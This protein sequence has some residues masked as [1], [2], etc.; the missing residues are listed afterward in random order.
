MASLLTVIAAGLAAC[1][2]HPSASA[3]GP[4]LSGG[5]ATFAL[6]PSTNPTYIFPMDD[7]SNFN[8][9][10]IDRLQYLLY[11]PLYWFGV[12][13]QPVFNASLSLAPA[14]TWSAD[15]LTATIHLKNYRWS[16]GQP[17][18]ASDVQLWQDIVDANAAEWG[19]TVPGQYPGN[20]V[21][22]SVINSTTISFTFNKKYN[23][24]WA[25]D[26]EL[27]Q[28]TP[29][30]AA[31]NVTSLGAP[32]NS[33]GC[34]P[35][36]LSKC[37]AVYKFLNA[38]AE[39]T[40]TYASSPLWSIVDGPW[41]LKSYNTT[42]QVAFVPNKAYSGPVKPSLSEFIEEPFTSD[43][44]EF[45]SVLS[46]QG[47]VDVGYLPPTDAQDAAHV[48]ADG[49][50]IS[51]WTAWAARFFDMNYNNPTAGPIFKQLYIRQAFEHLMDEK[52]II[53]SI[54]DGY[55]SPEYGPIPSNIPNPWV[56]SY[57]ESD[58]YPFSIPAAKSLITSHGWT[59]ENGTAVCTKPGTGPSDCGAGVQAGQ[60]LEFNLVYASGDSA[61][62]SIM[63]VYKSD[64]SEAGI[65][66]NLQDA[67]FSTV[68]SNRICQPG[69]ACMWDMI[70]WGGWTYS[71]D[72]YPEGS[73][74]FGT[75]AGANRGNYSNPQNDAN[76]AAVLTA[77][78]SQANAAMVTYENYL[79]Q[80]AAQI[81]MPE[82]PSQITVV[83]DTL[84]GVLPQNSLLAMTPE[85][86]Y[87]TK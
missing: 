40:S 10:N 17:V 2:S 70:A 47:G 24:Q 55:G 54:Y 41:K 72:Y 69:P 58:P 62:E 27:G 34:S 81:W 51:S 86:W 30:P 11:R 48:E 44:A 5:V 9:P 12:G 65:Q 75:G 73:L 3:S 39:D 56:S 36:Q 8:V 68:I 74:L 52:S 64:A 32:A 45:D 66:L 37:V 15:G 14:P 76:D 71:P 22:T 33:G 35:G 67:P 13:T 83:K 6:Q 20:V 25:L 63:E 61:L 1:S 26:N 21:S 80:Q 78:P 7:P 57:E 43:S 4:R 23:Q 50:T 38:Q 18:T 77:S 29:L 82:S 60:K 31:W 84:H 28:I 16:N 53:K 79:T 19:G 46:S 49:F 85:N 42:G 87:F 59:I